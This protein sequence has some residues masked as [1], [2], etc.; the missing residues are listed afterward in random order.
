[1]RLFVDVDGAKLVPDGNTMRERPTIV[2][3]HGGPGFDHSMF[4]AFYSQL[5]DISQ[6]V[7][8]DHRG[9]GRSEDGPRERWT[10]DQWADDLRALCDTLGIERPVVFG[11]S[12]GG[13][14]ALN[15]AAR[16]PDHPAKLII[17]ST[18]SKI[19]LDRSFAMFERVG[20]PEVRAVAERYFADPTKE[21]RDDYQRIVLPVYTQ[22]PFPPELVS[23]VRRRD[24]VAEH[25]FRGEV[26]TFDLGP[27]LSRVTCP[28]LQLAGEADPIVTIEDSEDLAAALPPHARFE[29]FPNA[30]HMLAVEDPE[31]V[32]RLVR[33]FVLDG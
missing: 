23:R 16:H 12:F 3:V 10:L 29:R 18:T 11:T 24:D 19:H 5:T 13:F 21:N 17:S 2:F 9:N 20:G 6:L 32:G 33:E 7:Y 8:Y 4:K 15:Y 30:G 28:V 22:R 31:R 25:F 14:V 27:R 26:L 1:V